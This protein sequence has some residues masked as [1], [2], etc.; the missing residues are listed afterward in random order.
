[1]SN[2]TSRDCLLRARYRTN[3]VA[4]ATWAYSHIAM[5]RFVKYIDR[6]R[7]KKRLSGQST[8]SS[9]QDNRGRL[10]CVNNRDWWVLR[11]LIV[12]VKTLCMPTRRVHRAIDV[13]TGQ[14]REFQIQ[15]Q[16]SSRGWRRHQLRI[17]RGPHPLSF[18]FNQSTAP[19]AAARLYTLPKT[20]EGCEG[21]PTDETGEIVRVGTTLSVRAC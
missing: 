4:S 6:I 16:I 8:C 9:F 18:L 20:E 1:M 11:E 21:A 17:S 2:T 14:G 12:Q 7:R 13:R 5:L 3:R 15:L 10:S 19:R